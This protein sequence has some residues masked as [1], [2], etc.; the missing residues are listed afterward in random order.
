MEN[1]YNSLSR[2]DQLLQLG[3]C[4]FMDSADFVMELRNLKTKK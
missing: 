1:Y 4:D 3:K 2:E